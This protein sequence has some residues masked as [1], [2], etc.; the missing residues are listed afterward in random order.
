MPAPYILPAVGDSGSSGSVAGYTLEL[1]RRRLLRKIGRFALL[2]TTSTPLT[3][4]T[5]DW[6]RQVLCA[7][8]ADDGKPMSR[9]NG[10]WLYVCDGAQAGEVRRVLDGQYHGGLG[11]LLLDRPFS[12]ALASGTTIELSD[13]LPAVQ[14]GEI[15]GA[16]EVINEALETLP[17]IDVVSVSA[18]TNQREYSLVYPWPVKVAPHV[19]APLGASDV[20]AETSL[21]MLSP[22]TVGFRQDADQSYVV[23]PHAYNTGQT[24]YLG[25]LRPA[26][27]WISVSGSWA[28]SSVGLVNDSDRALYAPGSVVRA[29]APLALGRLANLFPRGSNERAALLGEADT[30]MVKASISRF[31]NRFRGDGRQ[32]VGAVGGSR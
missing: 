25:L 7:G 24:F 18:V 14:H 11:S 17:V 29:A 4:V 31:Y 16:R 30:A 26:D 27:T 9:F 28:S 21:R 12:A 19:Y 15:D 1:Y 22:G 2:T 3:T 8:I 5:P 20:L 23:L 10:F 32:R 13:T 6:L